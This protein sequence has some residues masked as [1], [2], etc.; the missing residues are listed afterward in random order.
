MHL[1]L[2]LL[3]SITLLTIL[4]QDFWSRAIYWWLP[5]VLF[6]VS[7]AF[8]MHNAGWSETLHHSWYNAIFVSLLLGVLFLYSYLRYK[9]V[10]SLLTQQFGLGDVLMLLA[11]CPLFGSVNFILFI[12][13]S[14][15]LMLFVELLKRLVRPGPASIAYAGYLAGFTLMF[16]VLTFFV[17][18]VN[19]MTDFTGYFLFSPN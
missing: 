8:S 19:F 9:S 1:V 16:Q 18:G 12:C 10:S 6:L 17:P 7:G 14:N 11:L 3:L 2:H 15:V 13:F 4:V 5:V